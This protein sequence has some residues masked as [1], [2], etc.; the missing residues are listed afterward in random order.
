MTLSSLREKIQ[1][2]KTQY[3]FNEITGQLVLAD[4]IGYQTVVLGI[5]ANPAEL[6]T[7][8]FDSSVID[9]NWSAIEFA[10]ARRIILRSEAK[11]DESKASGMRF[12]S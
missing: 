4:R 7:L 9:E 3:C 11:A 5:A 8:L 2:Q 10:E 1:P 6:L 12:A